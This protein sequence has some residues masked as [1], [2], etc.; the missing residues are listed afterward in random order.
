MISPAN[1]IPVLE[2]YREIQKLD[3]FVIEQVCKDLAE[4]R[5]EHSIEFP[6]SVNFSRI[7]FELI[8]VQRLVKENLEKN[9]L[10]SSM[11]HIEVT[12]SALNVSNSSLQ[13][14]LKKLN[15][16]GFSLWL[17][18]F[19]SGYSG[20]NILTEYEFNM[21]KIDMGFLRNFYSNKKTKSVLKSI[22]SMAKEIGMQTLTEGVETEEIFEF[23]SSIGCDRIQGY[24][25]GKPMPKKE[26]LERIK[27]GEYKF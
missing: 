23:L 16:N 17:D 14:S 15:S 12:E 9:R 19:G 26:I 7:D 24:L 25:F 27:N 3:T 10:D 1:F 13:E 5:D 18:D 20:L 11:I 8:D 6:V 2:E 4:M 22:V 21:M